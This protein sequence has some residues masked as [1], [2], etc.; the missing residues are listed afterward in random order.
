MP[1]GSTVARD[2]HEKGARRPHRPL[3]V[4][5]CPVRD[6]ERCHLLRPQQGEPR[7]DQKKRQ[8]STGDDDWHRIS[9]MQSLL[10]SGFTPVRNKARARMSLS[11][12]FPSPTL[13]LPPVRSLCSAHRSLPFPPSLSLYYV[14]VTGRSGRRAELQSCWHGIYLKNPTPPGSRPRDLIG[15]CRQKAK[16]HPPNTHGRAR[17]GVGQLLT[18]VMITSSQI[19]REFEA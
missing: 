10:G 11:P 1:R 5:G 2:V 12:L 18:C 7:G 6:R 15:L 13:P 4:P 14:H 16:P 19:C 17:K 8:H 3:G 9:R